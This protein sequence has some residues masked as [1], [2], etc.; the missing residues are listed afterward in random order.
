MIRLA[1][2]A[3]ALTLSHRAASAH[4]PFPGV[5]DFYNGM[6]HPLLVP[7][8]LLALVAAALVIGQHAPKSSR[9][10]L[11]AFALALVIALVLP[12][13][14]MPGAPAA[15]PLA[16]ALAAGL[17]VAASLDI[18]VLGSAALAGLLGLLV[19]STAGHD[20]LADGLSGLSLAGTAL[21]ALVF[22]VIVAGLV[23]R[24]RR[25]WQKIG[26]RVLGSWV[27]ASGFLVLALSLA[28]KAA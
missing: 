10:A 9:F 23:S 15:V 7:A 6:L 25:P 13:L 21:G 4:S 12:L 18:G 3:A 1:L 14:G 20:A 27:A 19:G 28:P 11:P 2:A 24:F 22:V 16:L 5:G 8:Q 26:V 17:V